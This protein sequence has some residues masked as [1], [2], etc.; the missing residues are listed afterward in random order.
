MH[1]VNIGDKVLI[2]LTVL[3]EYLCDYGIICLFEI[4]VCFSICISR[5]DKKMYDKF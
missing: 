5:E 1:T 4:R 3:T 2:Q